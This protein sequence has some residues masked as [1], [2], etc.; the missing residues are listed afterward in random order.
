MP[1][2]VGQIDHV[3]YPVNDVE[4]TVVFLERVLDARRDREPYRID[5]RVAVQQL[6]VGDAMLSLH[7]RGNGIALVAPQAAPG[8][9]DICLVWTAPI[10]SAVAHLQAAAVEIVEG[11]VDR[12]SANGASGQSVYF[13]D[14]DGNL[15]ELMS[16][17]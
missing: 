1:Q 12:R 15:F 14:P 13:R 9:A 5:G 10:E 8:C 4:K 2:P 7:Q 6:R 17:E 3:A 11:P 16:V